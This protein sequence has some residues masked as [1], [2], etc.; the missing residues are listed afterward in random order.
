VVVVDGDVY[1]TDQ[2]AG[3]I[4]TNAVGG[5]ASNAATVATSPNKDGHAYGIAYSTFDAALFVGDSSAGQI[6]SARPTNREATGTNV[7]AAPGVT[8]LTTAG[9]SI[10]VPPHLGGDVAWT[11]YD[12]GSVSVG[13][14]PWASGTNDGSMYVAGLN[15]TLFWT[16]SHGNQVWTIAQGTPKSAPTLVSTESEPWGIAVD[17]LALG[18]VFWVNKK[19]GRIRHGTKNFVSN[20]WSAVTVATG[21]APSDIRA[22]ET[23]IYWTDTGSGR[24]L[25]LM[26]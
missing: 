8:G 25:Q 22:D 18:S 19:D 1:W 15:A 7:F 6:W 23:A 14:T 12:A 2:A 5:P 26:R 16:A 4:G 3:K 21:N 20:A 24:V 10:I 13:G 17:P 9:Q 11:S